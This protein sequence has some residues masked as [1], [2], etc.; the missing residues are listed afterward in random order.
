[1]LVNKKYDIFISYRHNNMTLVGELVHR[2][3]RYYDVFW[4]QRLESG[5]WNEQL[6]QA[7]DNSS[8][9]LINLN[10]G[11][12]NKKTDGEDWFLNEIVYSITT[13]QKERIIPVCYDGFAFPDILQIE[14]L[15]DEERE[16]LQLLKD[17]Y[18]RIVDVKSLEK[19]VEK[20]VEYLSGLGVEPKGV[21]SEYNENISLKIEKIVSVSNFVGR[22]KELQ[23][24]VELVH[25]NDIVFL[26]GMGGIGKTELARKFIEEMTGGYRC[27]FCKYEGSLENTLS[28]IEIKGLEETDFKSRENALKQLLNRKVVL[29]IDN[30][31]F[32]CD[33][34]IDSYIYEFCKYSC[35]KLITTRNS[36]KALEFPCDTGFVALD[37]LENEHIRKLFEDKYGDKITDSQFERILEFTGGLTLAVPILASLCMKSDMSV[38]ELC[39]K[40]EEG[41][42]GIENSESVSYV[43]DGNKKGNVPQILR[44]LFDMNTLND[45]KKATLCNLSL[46]QFVQVTKSVYREFA[47]SSGTGNLDAFNE[48]VDEGWIKETG[49]NDSKACYELHPLIN[50]IVKEDLKPSVKTSPQLFANIEAKSK[51]IIIR[52]F[53]GR[54]LENVDLHNPDNYNYFAGRVSN[55]QVDFY[56]KNVLEILLSKECYDDTDVV[57]AINMFGS[58]EIRTEKNTKALRCIVQKCFEGR[59]NKA[60]SEKVTKKFVREFIPVMIGIMMESDSKTAEIFSI[61]REYKKSL[62]KYLSLYLGFKMKAG[63]RYALSFVGE[64]EE[65]RNKITALETKIRNAESVEKAFELAESVWRRV[66]LED[67]YRDNV[68]LPFMTEN[69]TKEEVESVID[70][71]LKR[72]GDKD[73]LDEYG[74][75]EGEFLARAVISSCL[76]RGY[77]F[78]SY[79][80]CLKFVNA[81]YRFG[82]QRLK[83]CIMCND[84]EKKN[85]TVQELLCAKPVAEKTEQEL[86]SEFIALR[87]TTYVFENVY[88]DESADIILDYVKGMVNAFGDNKKYT[89]VVYA[90]VSF[91]SHIFENDEIRKKAKKIQADYEVKVSG[92]KLKYTV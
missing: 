15:T 26:S 84:P 18:Q 77:D 91:A 38:D 11:S 37:A 28:R 49:D 71:T 33:E 70:A 35:K 61:Y 68:F 21:F 6:T 14:G 85:A 79:E 54:F 64:R 51:D 31:D 57:L 8:V 74:I 58:T 92:I 17:K 80:K 23:E 25:T 43:K 30:F 24:M 13:K 45:E 48:L 56:C 5:Y 67:F 42:K 46:L 20:I 75:N 39:D 22:E 60:V 7:I 82:E 12:L 9:V 83:A 34:N 89:F 59:K 52:D 78:L 41:L 47:L 62:K 16:K 76:I 65:N 2:L 50:S 87:N 19:I 44:I 86:R 88:F 53:F 55:E 81:M 10:V 63:V 27:I 4:D 73:L 40:L 72:Y 66:V 3:E 69:A 32:N 1:M 90:W 36:F 29:V